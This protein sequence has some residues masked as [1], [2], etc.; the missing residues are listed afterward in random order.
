MRIL[1]RYLYRSLTATFLAVLSVLLLVAFGTETTR[2][3]TTAVEGDIPPGLV[4]SLLMYQF[5]PALELILPLVALLSVMLALGRLYQ[6]Q[7]MVA[8]QSAGLSMR[9]FRT[10]VLLFLLPWV[11]VAAGLSSGLTPW[12]HEQSRLLLQQGQS[13][14][15]ATALRAGRFN[16]L[17]QNQGVLYLKNREASGDMAGLWLHLSAQPDRGEMILM[18]PKGRFELIDGRLVL[19]LLQGHLYQNLDRPDQ[20]RVQKFERLEGGLPG[21]QPKTLPPSLAELGNGALWRSGEAEQLAL[22]QWRLSVPVSVLLMG[23]LGLKLSRTGPRQG[24]FAKV[25][26][27]LIVYVTY[28]QL[29]LT[30]RSLMEDGHWPIWLG[31]WPVWLVFWVWAWRVGDRVAQTDG[32]R[33]FKVAARKGVR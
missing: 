30:L 19:V 12:S 27:A 22:L 17:P 9:W 14:S 11:A 1:D 31:L 18:A 2:L 33:F 4:F 6:D 25:A 26:L 3:L 15:P 21:L 29:L 24:R 23:L 7:E 32:W 13:V 8:L 28:F 10:R 16:P 20:L 5:P